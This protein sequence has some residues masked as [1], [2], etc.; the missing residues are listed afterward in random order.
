MRGKNTAHKCYLLYP[1]EGI[2]FQMDLE[3][4]P[5]H[6]NV[7]PVTVEG[8]DNNDLNEEAR[9]LVQEWAKDEAM[10]VGLHEAE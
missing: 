4:H 6:I 3:L 9:D 10:R 7:S 2:V 5:N 8:I 1:E